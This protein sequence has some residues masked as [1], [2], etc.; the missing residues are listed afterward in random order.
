MEETFTGLLSGVA[1]GRR[2]W[3]RAPQNVNIATG[4]FLVLNRIDGIRDYTMGG[5]SGYVESRIQIDIY[6]ASYAATKQAARDAIAAL[7]G[8]SDGTIQGIFAITERDLPATDAGEV[9]QLFRTSVDF[10]VHHEET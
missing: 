8:H 5:A 1:G 7:S 3:G 2:Y 9:K 6:G 10:I 4:P